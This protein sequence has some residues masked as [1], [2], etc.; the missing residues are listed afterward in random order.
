VALHA[1]VER[2]PPSAWEDASL[3]Q[4]YSPRQAVHL[5]PRDALGVF[6]VG[7]LPSEPARREAIERAADRVCRILDGRELRGAHLPGVRVAC[8]T[9]RILVRW[10]ASDLLV[11]E[12][13]RPEIDPDEARLELAR[14]HLHAH[15]PTTP[16]AFAWWS[17]LPRRD[18]TVAFRRLV[19]EVLPVDL[20]E[21]PAWVLL[22]DEA[23]LRRNEPV[24][25]VRLLPA[26]DLRLFG[27]DRSER[28]VGP[29]VRSH[30]PAQDTHHPNGVLADGRV[31]GAWGRRGGEVDVVLASRTTTAQRDAIEAEARSMPIPN[32]SPEVRLRSVH[33]PG[34]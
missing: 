3:V 1:R 13:E 20:D 7:R 31:V 34:E 30:S 24:P 28:F 21:T 9:G 22:A 27:Q 17:G 29:G 8:A 16:A 19:D 18:A 15:G 2:C 5:L 4:T 6:T 23:E 14:R 10:T 25:A 26:P 12:V 32:G 33:S 11:R